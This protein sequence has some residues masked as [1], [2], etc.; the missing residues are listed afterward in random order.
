MKSK[1]NIRWLYYLYSLWFT[2]GVGC[3]FYNTRDLQPF[4]VIIV[5]ACLIRGFVCNNKLSQIIAV[6]LLALSNIP[7][8]TIIFLASLMFEHPWGL[9]LICVIVLLICWTIHLERRVQLHKGD[10]PLIIGQD[11]WISF[12]VVFA[13]GALFGLFLIWLTKDQ[14]HSSHCWTG[15]PTYSTYSTDSSINN[16]TFIAYY[17]A[18]DCLCFS[19]GNIEHCIRIESAYLENQWFY[20]G[21][22]RRKKTKSDEY[23]L[24]LILAND[25]RK[26]EWKTQYERR[27]PAA[28]SIRVIKLSNS[29]KHSFRYISK[30]RADTLV[31]QISNSSG[32]IGNLSLIKKD[33]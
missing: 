8:L 27:I 15:G 28:T 23:N 3:L 22:F 2:E 10:Y 16:Q 17:D 31:L 18:P 24:V 14:N 11:K 1:N 7:V 32:E 13:T 33:R 30:P 26:E 19:V 9:C 25:S 20:D 6:T 21:I 4:G 29:S 5:L 12:T